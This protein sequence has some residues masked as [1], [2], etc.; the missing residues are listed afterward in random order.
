MMFSI[1]E[2]KFRKRVATEEA[3]HAFFAQHIVEFDRAIISWIVVSAPGVA[4]E[5]KAQLEEG[6][7]D[8]L[9]LASPNNARTITQYPPAGP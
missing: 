7:A 6:E 2:Q 9:Y 4:G 8:F 1:L 3:V 5:W